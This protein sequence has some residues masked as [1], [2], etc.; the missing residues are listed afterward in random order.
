MD[1]SEIRSDQEEKKQQ[2]YDGKKGVSRLRDYVE[3]LT[4]VEKKTLLLPLEHAEALDLQTISLEEHEILLEDV[5][6]RLE[7]LQRK[8][9]EMKHSGENLIEKE[10]RRNTE[11]AKKLGSL[12]LKIDQQFATSFQQHLRQSSISQNLEEIIHEN[13]TDG[14][15]LRDSIDYLEKE[16][17]IIKMSLQVAE[18][19]YKT[20]EKFGRFPIRN[21]LFHRSST[22]EEKAF[23]QEARPTFRK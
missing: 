13:A 6:S 4:A 19:N 22:E 3:M 11:I 8:A 21:K 15:Q 20:I 5:S 23:Y 18:S 17:I 10:Q 14:V 2:T 16:Q 1:F 12:G 9:L 7:V